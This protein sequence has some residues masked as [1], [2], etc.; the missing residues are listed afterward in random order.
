MGRGKEAQAG[1]ARAT[2]AGS[3]TPVRDHL[4]DALYADLVGPF[5][6]ADAHAT[7]GE[8]LRNPSDWYLTGFLVPEG[9][10]EPPPDELEGPGEGE[11]AEAWE[12]DEVV[13]RFGRLYRMSMAAYELLDD[14]DKAA[15]VALWRARLWD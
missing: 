2:A 12:D 5:A 8:L 1:E 11:R 7:S 13:A 10:R 14:E 4:V 9:D 3:P 6:G 15:R